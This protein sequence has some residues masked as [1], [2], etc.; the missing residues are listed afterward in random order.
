MIII[1]R[2]ILCAPQPVHSPSSLRRSRSL[3]SIPPCLYLAVQPSA[4]HHKLFHICE[5]NTLQLLGEEIK[6]LQDQIVNIECCLAQIDSVCTWSRHSNVASSLYSF[7]IFRN[8]LCP[9]NHYHLTLSNPLPPRLCFFLV[10]LFEVIETE[11]TLYLVMEYASGGELEITYCHHT[12]NTFHQFYNGCLILNDFIL[13]TL[14][15]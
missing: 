11:R 10:K 3:S 2:V 8:I 14:C 5:L 4:A 7:L 12:K 15:L 13:N 1:T 6:R 9:W